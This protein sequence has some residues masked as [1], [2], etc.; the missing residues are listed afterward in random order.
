MTRGRRWF[1]FMVV[2]VAIIGIAVLSFL[3]GCASLGGEVAGDRLARVEASA[4]YRDGAFFNDVPQAKLSM[5]IY[6]D[7]IAEQFGG[8]QI[9]VPPFPIAVLPVVIENP[10]AP[11]P[12][13]LRAIWLGH[14]SVYVEIDGTRL[15][16]DPVFSDRP[17]PVEFLGPKRSHEPPISLPNLPKVDAVVI[18]HD[19]Y[20]HLDMPTIQHL[21]AKGSRFLVPLGIGAHLQAWGVPD[22][23]IVELEWWQSGKINGLEIFATPSRHYSGRSISDYKATLWS[24]WSIIGPR[25]RLY[26]SGDTGY[27]D[28]FKKIGD[29]FGPF[30]LSII[31]VGAY[32]PGASWMDSHM[33][34]EHAVQANVD[35]Q[36]RRMLPVHWAT[37]N[38]AFHDW[39]EPIQRAVQAA[40]K[41]NVDLAIPRI[42]EIVDA[43]RPAPKLEWWRKVQ[44]K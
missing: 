6:W 3:T 24:S 7:Y 28:H 19:H 2:V 25:H 26:Y 15:L 13:G 31:K 21:S 44:E 33:N 37:F 4:Q 34:P 12:D 43:D 30:D 1:I 42:G 16:V 40:N 29:K 22:T 5:G 18:S 35:V 39:D 32:G 11:P 9:R 41:A 38:L 36:A 10:D 14:A 23:Q 17:S 8:D 27:S 20:D